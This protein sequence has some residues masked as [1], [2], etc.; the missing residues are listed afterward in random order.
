MALKLEEGKHFTKSQWT[1]RDAANTKFD[2]LDCTKCQFSTLYDFKMQEHWD[3]AYGPKGHQHQWAHP[4][5]TAPGVEIEHPEA[6]PDKLT[7]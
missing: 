3:N 7:Y 6:K 1:G 2:N 5:G 4:E